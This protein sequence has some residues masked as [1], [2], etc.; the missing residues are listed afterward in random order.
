[1]HNPE[2][3]LS[4]PAPAISPEDV[5][6]LLQVLRSPEKVIADA[7][8]TLSERDQQRLKR[9]WLTAREIA[10]QMFGQETETAQRRV[11]AIASAARPAVVSFPGSLGYNLWE[12]CTLEEIN[13]GIESLESQGKDMIRQANVYRMAYHRRFRGRPVQEQT[14]ALLPTP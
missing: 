8:A 6:K 12:R 7:V 10:G 14:A 3:D 2:L 9:G 11:R 4:L 1:M 13:N 5:E